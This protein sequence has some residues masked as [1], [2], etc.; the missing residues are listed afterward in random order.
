MTKR[1]F[2]GEKRGVLFEL[3]NKKVRC[4]ECGILFEVKPTSRFQRKYCN[5]CSKENRDYYNN[6]DSVAAEDCDD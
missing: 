6:L 1:K 3:L 4:K 2:D 5:K